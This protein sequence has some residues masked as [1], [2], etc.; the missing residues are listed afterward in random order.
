MDSTEATAMDLEVFADNNS[1]TT[2]ERM[3]TAAVQ[4]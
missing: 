3:D 1:D 4:E 2:I